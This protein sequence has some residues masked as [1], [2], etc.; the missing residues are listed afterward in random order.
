MKRP[1]PAH[2]LLAACLAASGGPAWAWDSPAPDVVLYCT[3]A[4]QA[5]LRAL[6]TRYTAASG[7][8]VHILVGSPDGQTGLIVHRARADVLVAEAPVIGTL[9]AQHLIRE[10]SIVTL[11]TDGFVLIRQAGASVPSG[12]TPAQ[13]VA[14]HTTV[15]PDPT[16]AGSFDGAAVLRE[17]VPADAAPRIMGV[18]DTPTV[19]ARVQADA[20]LLGVVNNTAPKHA[21]IETA[22]ALPAAAIAIDGALLSNGQSRNAAAL[23]AFI[24]STQGRATL[25]AAGLEMKS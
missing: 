20:T 4:M 15:V 2:L 13:L 8:P 12:A 24:A 11:G 1:S 7:V 3:P 17:A 6:A 16:S 5:S 22:A 10:G 23:L 18:A 14:A 21:R 19:I 9:N 25:G